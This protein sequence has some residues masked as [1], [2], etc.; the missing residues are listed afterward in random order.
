MLK[1]DLASVYIVHVCIP[2]TLSSLI[3]ENERGQ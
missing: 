1:M 2:K 3:R